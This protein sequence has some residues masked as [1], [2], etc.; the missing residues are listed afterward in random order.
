MV[1]M[2]LKVNTISEDGKWYDDGDKDC[3]EERM[4]VG[5]QNCS[6]HDKRRPQP[7]KM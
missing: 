3:E 1:M 2:K 6:H 5:L 4:E 7:F